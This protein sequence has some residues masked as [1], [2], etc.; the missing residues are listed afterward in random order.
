MASA[1]WAVALAE[2]MLAGAAPAAPIAID[3]APG[4][5]RNALVSL[6][7]QTGISVGMSG[8]LPN[9]RT[10]PV[11]GLLEPGEALERLLANSRWRA[12]RVDGMTWRIEPRP[13]PQPIVRP[14][15]AVLPAPSDDIIVTATKRDERLANVPVAISIL[16]IGTI[17]APGSARSVTDL[18]SQTEGAFSTNL[19]AGR[20]RFF[21]RGVADSPFN[22]PTQSTVGLYLDDARISYATPDPDLRLLDVERVELLRGPQGALYGT[23][24]LGGIIRIVTAR[25]VLD[26][27]SG[28]GAIEF[29]RLAHGAAGG[30]IDAVFNVP[31]VENRLGLR[32]IGY[33]ELM[34]GWIDDS[35]RGRDNVNRVYRSGGRAALRWQP[36]A[37]WTV[38][39]SFAGQALYA[40]DSQYATAGLTRATALAEPHD[41]DFLAGRIEVHG[42][43]ADLNLLSASAIVTHAVDSRFDAGAVAAAR[44]LATPLAYQDDRRLTLLTQ[45]MRLSDPH[46]RR[47]WV[48]GGS[49][50]S[51][52]ASDSGTFLPAGGAPV[53]VRDQD[54]RT[55]EAAIFGEATQ[56][57]P[58]RIDLSIGL[59][60]FRSTATN[61]AGPVRH[62]HLTK[63]GVTPSATLAWRPAD[64][65]LFWLR[66]ASAIRPGG[67][68]G[69]SSG[70]AG[71]Q[72]TFRSD[73]LRS[74]E[75]GARLA[76]FD[77]RLAFEGALFALSWEDLQSD[78]IGADGLVTTINA[79]NARNIGAELGAKLT[80]A[81]FTLEGGTTLQHGRLNGPGPI[82]G[83]NDDRHLPVVPDISGHIRLSAAKPIGAMNGQA[84]VALRYTG[85]ARLSF[86]PALALHMG[87]YA[88][89]DSG[90]ALSRGAWKGSIGVT[91]LLDGRGDSFS[92]G[93]PFTFRLIGQQTP[94]RPRA[95]SIRIERR[96]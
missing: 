93:N 48:I 19:G 31:L 43:I 57:L 61:E 46:A 51:A 30:A 32:L 28:G 20:D 12:V 47:P 1:W 23:G 91:N 63:I 8:E 14:V 94:V 42:R 40:R 88:V 36:V 84:F 10:P 66:Y 17:D 37:D 56:P 76:L 54:E 11:R 53:A 85:K 18:L 13:L 87:N 52:D 15:A 41:N 33:G 44:G 49:L 96:F 45:E 77:G 55:F 81:P 70:E 9:D 26:R 95:V 35:R 34:P 68:N 27:W 59:R 5:L 16:P 79:G 60:A 73:E 80:F 75:L 82:P 65:S 89:V 83:G 29:D 7:R 58:H 22:G 78:V 21:L 64:N 72:P 62:Q 6:S 71:S 92:F 67:L 86:D 38:D 39:A 2:L 90:I 74:L 3:I 25:P 24:S 69:D 4:H 50:L